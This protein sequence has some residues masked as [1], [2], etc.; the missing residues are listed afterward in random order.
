M[1]LHRDLERLI[2]EGLVERVADVREISTDSREKTWYQEI[3]TGNLYV[4]VAPWERGAPEF[5]RCSELAR[6]LDPTC[7]S[8]SQRGPEDRWTL[9]DIWGLITNSAITVAPLLQ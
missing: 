6:D 5:R 8:Q 2:S 4:Y 9:A 7:K 3:P 1:L